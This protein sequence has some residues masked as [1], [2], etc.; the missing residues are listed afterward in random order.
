VPASA[1]SPIAVLAAATGPVGPGPEPGQGGDLLVVLRAVPDPRQRRG[2]RHRLVTVLA[3]SVAAVLAGARSYVAIAEWAQDLPL[4]ARVRLGVGRRAPSESTIRRI[5]QLVDL[6]ALDT[7]L[8]TWLAGRLAAGSS[9]RPGSVSRP[10][11]IARVVAVDGKTARGARRPDRPAV[12]MLAAFDHTSGIVLGQTAVDSKSNEVTA[13][14]PLL[15]RLDL[16][17]VLVTADALHTHRGHADYLHARGGHYL[18]I[19]KAN[20]PRLHTQLRGLPWAQIPVVDT[21]GRPRPRP[22]RT[23]S[24]QAHR[25][26]GGDRVP[27]RPDRDPGSAATPP[28]RFPGLDQR[29][30]LRDHQHELA[31]SPR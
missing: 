26:R 17:D 6:D 10:G 21:P 27:V 31:P 25:G 5:L 28:D 2:Q 4:S 15:D 14:S 16:A 20:Q 8:S 29:D 13:F 11:S 9:S 7:V 18:W 22:G 24:G 3:V 1:S 19:V 12:H 23:T 30:D